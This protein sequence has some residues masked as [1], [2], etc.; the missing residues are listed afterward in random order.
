MD[1]R[2]TM[3]ICNPN[4][5]QYAG[6]ATASTADSPAKHIIGFP[7]SR[8]NASSPYQTTSLL[9]GVSAQ[10]TPIQVLLNA[11]T[12]FNSAMIFYLIAEYSELIV[13]DVASKQ[14]SV[15]N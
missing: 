1:Q 5:N 13:I 3:S 2:N 12:A 6:N 11:G 9:A 8:L 14:V 7:L 4:F 15:I 10:Q